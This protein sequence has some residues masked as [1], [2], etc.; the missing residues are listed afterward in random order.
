MGLAVLVILV[1]ATFFNNALHFYTRV[2]TYP[3]FAWVGREEFV[4]FHEEYERRLPVAIYAPYSLLMGA[5]VL[6]LFAHP[7]GVGLSWVVALLVLNA[8]IMIESLL[9]AAPV[10]HRMDREGQDAEGI[11]RLVRLNALRL[12]AST[13]SSAVVLY[14]LVGV[15]TG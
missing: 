5:N 3:L 10:H 13:A 15:L 12:V 9:F 6:L 8:F 7:E 11:R 4:S 1:F 2:Q 14:L